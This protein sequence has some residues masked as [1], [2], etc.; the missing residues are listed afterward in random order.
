MTDTTEQADVEVRQLSQYTKDLSFENPKG[1]TS[2]NK[3]NSQRPDI[4][5]G[6]QV[7]ASK[8]S[9]DIYESVIELKVSA[10]IEEEVI[11]IVELAFGSAWMVRNLPDDQLSQFLLIHAPSMTFPFAR[12][13][14]SDL[15][16]DGSFPPLMLDPIDFSALY[17]HNVEQQ[18]NEA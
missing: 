12:R 2:V 16:R 3:A 17:R 7:Q 4:D 14:V 9:D 8:I 1:V 18:N 6:V 15:T 10:K 11:F 5:I 13:I